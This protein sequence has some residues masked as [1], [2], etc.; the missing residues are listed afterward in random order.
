M[1]DELV[2]NPDSK[3]VI[4]FQSGMIAFSGPQRCGRQVINSLSCVE[5]LAAHFP[6]V[7]CDLKD[8]MEKITDRHP[9]VKPP[10]AS[11]SVYPGCTFNLGP[12]TV[13][14]EHVDPGNK[15]SVPCAITSLGS[16]DPDKGGHLY[17]VDLKLIIRF[18][19]GSTIL[20]SSASIRHANLPIQ[21]SETR[22]SV[23]QFCP[24]GLYRWVRHGFR[25]ACTLSKAQRQAYD[26][27]P[28][29]RWRQGW[30][31]LSTPQT[32]EADRWHLVQSEKHWLE[33]WN[34]K[35]NTAPS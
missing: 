24:G 9:N 19:P 17:L 14:V 20:I 4:S 35:K 27:D 5:A 8:T 15:P 26:G 13:T 33:E 21:P 31:L 18:P 3:R 25:P 11:H 1:V 10:F 29:V 16:Y 23:T 7:Y 6:K 28:E 32:L 34:A 2:D 22:Y 12:Q 30:A